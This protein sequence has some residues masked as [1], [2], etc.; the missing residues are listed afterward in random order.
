MGVAFNNDGRKMDPFLRL[1][2]SITKDKSRATLD[3]QP[4][5]HLLANNNGLSWELIPR[6]M[7]LLAGSALK[8]PQSFTTQPSG[9]GSELAFHSYWQGGRRK[10]QRESKERESKGGRDEGKKER[11]RGREKRRGE[12]KERKEIEKRGE[13]IDKGKEGGRRKEGRTQKKGGREGK[14]EKQRKCQQKPKSHPTT[15]A[16][17]RLGEGQERKITY[18]T[19]PFFQ[20]KMKSLIFCKQFRLAS[21]AKGEVGRERGGRRADQIRHTSTP[22]PISALTWPPPQPACPPSSSVS[23]ARA[24]GGGAEGVSRLPNE[25]SFINPPV[26]LLDWGHGWRHAEGR[27]DGRTDGQNRPFSMKILRLIR[28]MESGTCPSSSL[29]K[30]TRCDMIAAF[31]YLRAAPKKR[32]SSYSPKHQKATMELL[33][34]RR[35]GAPSPEVFKNRLDRSLKEVKLEGPPTSLSILLFWRRR[36]GEEER[37]GLW[38]H[39]PEGEMS[40]ALANLAVINKSA[41]EDR[42]FA[43]MAVIESA[44]SSVHRAPELRGPSAVASSWQGNY[45]AVTAGRPAVSNWK[46]TQVC[47]PGLAFLGGREEGNKSERERGERE[48]EG[49]EGG[50]REGKRERKREEEEKEREKERERKERRKERKAEEREGGREEKEERERKRGE[51]EGRKEEEKEREKG[52]EGGRRKRRKEKDRGERG[53]KGGREGEEERERKEVREKEGKKKR[54]KERGER[55]WKGG[56]REGK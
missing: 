55:E 39:C 16:A 53:K 35:C 25:A 26:P 56:G 18:L 17:H 19:P 48:K 30:R 51:R 49:R 5:L 22:S 52:R 12:E 54:R 36:R 2:G 38:I 29:V 20:M 32:G 27:T 13:D 15:G 10:R 42:Q 43:P 34:T 47:Q 8:A 4:G 45:L 44:V 50:G 31:Q 11:E 33:A 24:R 6:R 7:L 21:P 1:V 46:G 28:V 40:R 3:P 37:G 41:N 23:E 14:E 9:I